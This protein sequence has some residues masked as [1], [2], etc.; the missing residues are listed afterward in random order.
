LNAYGKVRKV[1]KYQRLKDRY[2]GFIMGIKQGK[3][4]HFS[5]HAITLYIQYIHQALLES[6]ELK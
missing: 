2:R 5:D 3:I 1:T 6:G 4:D